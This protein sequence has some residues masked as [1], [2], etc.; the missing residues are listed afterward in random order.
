[1]SYG[2]RASNNDPDSTIWQGD[3]L[4]LVHMNV[5]VPTGPYGVNE[6]RTRRCVRARARACVCVCVCVCVFDGA[7]FSWLTGSPETPS[8]G[9]SVDNS[10]LPS[11]LAVLLQLRARD[12]VAPCVHSAFQ[13][14]HLLVYS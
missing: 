3:S 2:V 8:N 10:S 11:P 4:T 1:M 12:L 14:L 13:V 6:E 9:C 5:I 7:N